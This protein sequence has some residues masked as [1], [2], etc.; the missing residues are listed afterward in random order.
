MHAAR[1]SADDDLLDAEITFDG[2]RIGHVSGLVRDPISQRVRR[3]RTTYGAPRRE[4]AVAIEWVVR[5]TPTRLTLGVGARS[6]DDLAV[7]V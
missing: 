4:V 7:A 5:R 1:R 6:L 2:A 3:P